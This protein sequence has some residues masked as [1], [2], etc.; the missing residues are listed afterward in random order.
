[1]ALGRRTLVCSAVIAAAAALVCDRLLEGAARVDF[2][3]DIQPIF[4]ASCYSCHEGSKANALLRL[5]TKEGALKGGSSGRVILPGNSRKSALIRRLT[6]PDS[7]VRMPFG[8]SPLPAQK[9]ALLRA[10]FD[11]GAPW[12][13]S[14]AGGKHW[15]YVSPQRPAAPP[16]RNAAWVKNPIDRFVL[17]RLEKEGLAPSPEASREA[18][19]RR[20]S[21][22][23][24][25][26]PPTVDEI[27]AFLADRGPDAYEK[28]VERLLASPHYGERWTR[29]WLDL[30]RYADTNGYEKDRRRSIW[31]YRDWVIQALNQD[32]PF[33]QFTIE[34]I[35]GDML[36][37]PT[38]DQSIATGF[39]RNTMFNEEGGVD[40]EEAHWENLVDR[41]STTATVWLGTTLACAQ[42][43][44]H[45]YDPFTQREYYQLLAFFNNTDRGIQ[46]YGDTSQK[47]IEPQLDLPTPEQEARRRKLQVEIG[48][49]D[50]RLRT[51]T[52]ELEQ[53]QAAWE[54]AV[55]ASPAAWTTLVPSTL[56]AEN[57]TTLSAAQDGAILAGGA[58]PRQETYLVEARAPLERI[59]GIRLEALPQAS[60]P[61]GGPG[62]DAYGNFFLTAFEVEAG[63]S[64]DQ[65][66]KVAVGDI[67]VD[68][69]SIRQRRTSQLWT[70]DAS[71][72]DQRLPR[73][74]VFVLDRPA[75]HGAET[76]L[77]IRLRQDSAFNCQGIGHF[78]LSVTTA[79][80]PTTIVNISHRLRPL[81]ARPAEQRTPAEQ[82]ELA[83]N[84][85]S[86][87]PSLRAARKQVESLRKQL[88]AV[89]IVSTLIVRERPSFE[90]PAAHLR[91]R[92]SF[93]SKGELVHANVPA[94]LHRL[95]ESELANR[96]GLARWL[97]SKDNPLTARVTVNR[98]WE[99]YFER[100]LVETSEDFG[101]QGERP[102]HPELLDWLAVEFMERNWSMKAIHRLIVTSA[103]YSQSSRVP[104]A[105]L[106]RDPHNRLLARG[107]RFRLDA[108]RIR[109]TVLA[110][111]GLLSRKIGGPSVFPPQPEGVWDIPYNDDRW[112]ESA[113]EDRYRRGLYTFVRRTAPHPSML[114]FDATSREVCTVRRART[115]TPLQAL[116]ALN[117]PAFFE[118]ALGLARRIVA[119]GG[120]DSRS[121]AAFAF[122]LCLARPPNP[123]EL[124]RVLTAFEKEHAFFQQRREDVEKLAGAN[125]PELAAWTVVSNVLL[126]LDET[127]TKE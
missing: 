75:G 48:E 55:A 96:L 74:I 4:R 79:A 28:L 10:W 84:Y 11:Q 47:Y 42:C 89:G 71:R 17:A 66:Q 127:V 62:R 27:D 109:D 39:H 25:G 86:V 51:A 115:N 40:K 85:R 120:S 116:T 21:F 56:R 50:K 106:E 58:T 88:D 123:Q 94:A 98:F 13:E 122:R 53:E 46:E 26:L 92:G 6:S 105:L 5:D 68:N 108:E 91:I 67:Q 126:N 57:G 33:D 22:D 63:S 3:R 7:K 41:V 93:L 1:M 83:D 121:R 69:G 59:T 81:L 72:E 107:P 95:P 110:A 35:A 77:R 60:L 52:P 64:P 31:K 38:I 87:A 65:L 34:Q 16:V 45:K 80:D 82:K 24:I 90:R 20:L 76:L 103:T 97:V 104:A 112:V 8:L 44:N 19:I 61:R 78:R 29:P 70:V 111:S 49:L 43:H 2:L 73:Q 101:A 125:Q 15:A 37:N 118:A 14:A 113:G 23:L 119:Q 12:P 102:A 32:M 99:Q 114:A 9:I 54:G 117:D 124:D 30:A 36:P 18:L 100:G